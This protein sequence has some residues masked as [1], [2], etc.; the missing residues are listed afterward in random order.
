MTSQKSWQWLVLMV[1][2]PTEGKEYMRNETDIRVGTAG[3]IKD[4]LHVSVLV[5]SGCR[6]RSGFA[7]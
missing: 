2:H 3:H 5:S 7:G 6:P 4:H 1:E